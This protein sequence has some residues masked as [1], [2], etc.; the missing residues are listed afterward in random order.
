MAKG[1]TRLRENPRTPRPDRLD[2]TDQHFYTIMSAHESACARQQ[3]G[4]LD[5]FT[6]L[7]VM[8]ADN[9]MQRGFCCGRGCRHCPFE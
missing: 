9:H 8:T 7:F 5:P 3:A 6:G 1:E 2:P 4:Y